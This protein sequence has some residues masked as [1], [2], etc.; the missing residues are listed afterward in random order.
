VRIVPSD[1]NIN[2]SN[3][4]TSS[5]NIRVP[6][7]LESRN[8]GKTSAKSGNAFREPAEHTEAMTPVQVD[9]AT[10]EL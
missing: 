4:D 5:L 8:S 10:Q 1:I 6:R 3:K 2:S 7:D 9:E